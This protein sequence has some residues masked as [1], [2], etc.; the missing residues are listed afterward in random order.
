MWLLTIP[1]FSV[2]THLPLLPRKEV[3]FLPM[4]QPWIDLR[5]F[6]HCLAFKWLD[7]FCFCTLWQSGL[8]WSKE[9]CI[10]LLSEETG[11][12]ER[13]HM[14]KHWGTKHVHEVAFS[15]S[16]SCTGSSNHVN[17]TES[18]P[19]ASASGARLEFLT[20]R[21]ISND[22]LLLCYLKSPCIGVVC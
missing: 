11:G 14:E 16:G 18:V 2:C 17:A 1:P 15:L 5:V 8:P 22:K 10:I 4:E 19:Q 3:C 21:F 13:T 12:R 6:G 9:A 7:S 20:Q